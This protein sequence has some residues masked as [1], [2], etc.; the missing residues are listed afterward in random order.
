MFPKPKMNAYD[1]FIPLA[2]H[3]IS[4]AGYVPINSLIFSA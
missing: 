1:A 3:R 2:M 4:V